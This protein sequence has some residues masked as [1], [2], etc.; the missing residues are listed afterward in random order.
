MFYSL[1]GAQR[2]NQRR[3]SSGL[4]LEGCLGLLLGRVKRPQ[5]RSAHGHA[6]DANTRWRHAW[7]ACAWVDSVQ[8]PCNFSMHR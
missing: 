2:G 6:G 4:F 7:R 3:Q 1:T 8:L 5:P